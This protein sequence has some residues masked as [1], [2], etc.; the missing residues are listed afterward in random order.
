MPRALRTATAIS[1]ATAVAAVLIVGHGSIAQAA[2]YD[3]DCKLILCL[4]AGFPEGCGDALDHMIDRLRDGK[5][6]VGFCAMSDGKEFSDYDLDYRWIGALSPA[7]W[8][9]AAGKKLHHNV[10]YDDDSGRAREVTAFCYDTSVTRRFG[11]DF[12]TSYTGIAEPVRTDLEA[13]IQIEPGTAD[14][15]DS[16][17]LRFRTGRSRDGGVKISYRP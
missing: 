9:C 11:D 17:L 10:I 4:P 5:S 16:G 12:R 8:T 6:P 13:R 3:M 7:A 1:L 15:W 2:D 14:A